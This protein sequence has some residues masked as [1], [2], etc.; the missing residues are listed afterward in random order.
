MG[1]E[2]SVEQIRDA[3]SNAPRLFCHIRDNNLD[4]FMDCLDAGGDWVDQGWVMPGCGRMNPLHYA[5]K[6]G[7]LDMVVALLNGGAKEFASDGNYWPASYWAAREA[8]LSVVKVLFRP[9][10]LDVQCNHAASNSDRRVYELLAACSKHYG[11][12]E[13]IN[14]V[15]EE[16]KQIYREAVMRLADRKKEREV[17]ERAEEEQRQADETLRQEEEKERVHKEKVQTR[18][19][20]RQKSSVTLKS[21]L[22]NASMSVKS[23]EIAQQ[24]VEMLDAEHREQVAAADALEKARRAM[25]LMHDFGKLTEQQKVDGLEQV[26]RVRDAPVH[27]ISTPFTSKTGAGTAQETKV[28][29]HDPPHSP[30]VTIRTPTRRKM[31][32]VAGCKA[33]LRCASIPR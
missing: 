26:L 28:R 21:M 30:T 4:G 18:E 32:V 11:A 25:P 27:L 8:N 15:E 2:Q 20:L 3:W 29:H 24:R 6:L 16:G 5:A 33:G 14:Q 23:K 17:R 22:A 9:F 31:R 1:A 7:R 19:M 13:K 10:H 12:Q